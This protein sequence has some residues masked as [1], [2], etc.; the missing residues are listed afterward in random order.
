MYDV[1][2]ADSIVGMVDNCLFSVHKPQTVWTSGDFEKE[3]KHARISHF[4]IDGLNIDHLN[5]GVDGPFGWITSGTVDISAYIMIPQ[6]PDNPV[7][8]LMVKELI[9]RFD[10]VVD[11]EKPILVISTGDNNTKV[12]T[13]NDMLKDVRAKSNTKPTPLDPEASLVMN[14]D[15][16]FNNIKAVVPLQTQDVTYVNNALIRP[17]VAYMNANRTRLPIKCQLKLDL[18]NFDGSWTIYDSC[19]VDSLSEEVGKAFAQLVQDERERNRRLKRVGLWSLQSIT[20]SLISLFEYARGTRGFWHF[21]G[22]TDLYDHP[23]RS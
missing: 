16:R 3:L 13:L 7:F 19:L 20:R 5:A 2:C 9:D 23:I 22:L 4:K 1:I 17:I 6:N 11:F 21:M 18:S 10:D 14:M 12:I 8:K 15:I